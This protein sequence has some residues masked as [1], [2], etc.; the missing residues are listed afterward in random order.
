[1]S[2]VYGIIDSPLCCKDDSVTRRNITPFFKVDLSEDCFQ[3][4][5]RTDPIFAPAQIPSIDVIDLTGDDSKWFAAPAGF[6]FS[7]IIFKATRLQ[8]SFLVPVRT[9]SN[10]KLPPLANTL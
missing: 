2:L 6:D 10:T 9:F 3:Y 8:P 4:L 7:D 1:M 5:M